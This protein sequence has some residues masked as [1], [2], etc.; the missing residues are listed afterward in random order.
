MKCITC[1]LTESPDTA[2]Q[3]CTYDELLQAAQADCPRCTFV[4]KCIRTGAAHI[5]VGDILQVAASSDGYVKIHWSGG[6]ISLEVFN[7][8]G[9]SLSSKLLDDE[10]SR[11]S[12][13]L[14]YRIILT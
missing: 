14:K 6:E 7:E 11:R 2:D 12:F 10:G 5:E 4:L 1:K 8:H 13:S 3:A 9:K